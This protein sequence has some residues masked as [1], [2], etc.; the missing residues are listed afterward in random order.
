MSLC[1]WSQWD[2]Q[3]RRSG[4]TAGAWVNAA[5]QR[6]SVTVDKGR[7]IREW[8]YNLEAGVQVLRDK[9]NLA[10][11]GDPPCLVNL[12]NQTASKTVLENWYYAIRYYYGSTKP[13]SEYLDYIYSYI[14]NPPSRLL[15]FF[16]PVTI[17]KPQ[18]VIPGFGTTQGFC[19]QTNG[20]WT[21]YLC[22]TYQGTVHVSSS[23]GS[24]GTADLALQ[25]IS[26]TQ[27][28]PV[29]GGGITVGNVVQN[30]GQAASNGYTVDFYA[31]SDTNI[32]SS[33]YFIGRVT[34]S[35]LAGGATDPNTS[36]TGNLPSNLPN[37]T[38]YIGA[39]VNV[40]PD[41]NLGNNVNYDHSPIIVGNPPT[42]RL[43][44]QM[45]ARHGTLV[46][47]RP[48]AG[49]LVATRVSS[50]FV[51]RLSTN[52]GSSYTDISSHLSSSTRTF[53]YTPSSNQVTSTAVCWVV[54]FDSSNA[55]LVGATSSGAFTIA[56]MPETVSTPSTP[57]GPTSGSPGTVY[58]YSSSG[59]SSNLGHTVQYL[60]DWGDGNTSGW[61]PVGTT[62]ASHSWSSTETYSVRAQ[63]RCATHTSI[64]SSLSGALSVV[65][66]TNE[67]ISTPSTPSGPTNGSPGTSYSYSSSGASS[68]LGHT[69][70]V[71]VRLG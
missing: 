30:V 21:S 40:S 58:S 6:D 53:P 41:A 19:A 10:I 70:E 49:R 11:A 28:N 17:T 45:P 44:A 64:T 65:I 9:Y 56:N 3:F 31:S 18:Q 61:L 2:Y 26:V 43:I 39:I 14:Q 1:L 33:D 27:V 54:A 71:S 37:G 29:P 52:N 46:Q 42:I 57:S 47:A 8:R 16:P 62:S 63:A 4:S 20:T 22:N 38:Y 69:V 35:G 5:Y 68:N 50:Y 55:F 67:V 51:V 32:T 7:L 48:L 60:F 13:D 25:S 66:T 12:R 34:R 23:F 36:T 15:G 24:G 59:A